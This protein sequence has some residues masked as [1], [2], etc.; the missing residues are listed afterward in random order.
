MLLKDKQRQLDEA[1]S[2]MKGYKPEVQ[3]SKDPAH[4][5][6]ALQVADMTTFM[7]RLLYK[8]T[9]MSCNHAN[10]F[11]QNQNQLA[12]DIDEAQQSNQFHH[13]LINDEFP[14]KKQAKFVLTDEDMMKFEN[15]TQ[16]LTDENISVPALVQQL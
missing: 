6:R 8:L 15:N 14:I 1:R 12:Q 11:V 13:S 2:N 3:S 10:T 5:Y 16:L 7:A 9:E 4:N